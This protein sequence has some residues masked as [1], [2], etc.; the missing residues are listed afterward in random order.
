MIKILLVDDEPAVLDLVK[1][2]LERTGKFQVTTA[3]SAGE[4]LAILDTDVFDAVISDYEM[5]EMDGIA[6]LREIRDRGDMIPFVI[7]TGRSREEVVIEALNCGADY[8]IQKGGDP[9]PLFAELIHK[10]TLAVE[11]KKAAEAL[12]KASEY[13]HRLIEAHMDPLLTIDRDY[14]VM[15]MNSAMERL[16]GYRMEEMEGRDIAGLFDDRAEA[17]FALEK[18]FSDNGLMNFPLSILNSDGVTIPVL[19]HAVPYLGENSEFMGFFTEFHE[20]RRA[21]TGDRQFADDPDVLL[22]MLIHDIR[23]MI[24]VESGY[25]EIAGDGGGPSISW[26]RRME[27]LVREIAHLL[28]GIDTIRSAGCFTESR[29]HVIS[30][31]EVISGEAAFYPDLDIRID[32]RGYEVL[33]GGPLGSA[34]Y[35]LFGNVRKHCGSGCPVKIRAEKNDGTVTVTFEDEGPG[36]SEEIMKRFNSGVITPS[37]GS[38]ESGLGLCIIRNIVAGCGGTVSVGT[39]P[40][41][42][43]TRFSIRLKSPPDGAQSGK[44]IKKM[45]SQ[46]Q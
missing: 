18:A 7:F 10:I 15:D 25:L 20:D 17:E 32:C 27:F 23:N 1:I 39:V 3:G 29:F 38:G 2:F 4:G 43:G 24:T 8:Y 21:D 33:S 19:L 41:P 30:L 44:N 28:N 26:R 45:Q 13:R 12:S 5:P 31:K 46:Y 16:S 11:R 6:F 9:G 22:G 42:C 37:G 40:D 36:I 35:N 34:F 14:R